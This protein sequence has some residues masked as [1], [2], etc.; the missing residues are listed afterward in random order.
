VTAGITALAVLLVLG[1][2]AGCGKQKRDYSSDLVAAAQAFTGAGSVHALVNAAV[3]PLEGETGMTVNVQGDAW[4]D[5][6]A[7]ALEARFTVLGMEVSLRYVGG[8]AYLKVGGSWYSLSAESLGVSED[9]PSS[10]A[11]LLAALPEVLSASVSVE[12]LG[13]KKVG[14]FDCVELDVHPDIK[15]ISELE[16]V[17]KLAED[18]DIAPEELEEIL[19]GSN[20]VIR[21]CLQKGAPVVRQVYMAADVELSPFNKQLGLGLLPEKGRLEITADFPEYD[22]EVTVEPPAEARPF[23]G[24]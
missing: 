21:V 1:V 4:V 14:T 7:P 2:G 12:Y 9:I 17:R 20:P 11:D 13:E 10:L 15:A 18:L 6:R 5:L 8:Q 24:L 16:E 3:S 22:V 19:S 23:R